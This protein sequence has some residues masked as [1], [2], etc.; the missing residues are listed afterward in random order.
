[1]TARSQ[2]ETIRDYLAP[3]GGQATIAVE[4]KAEVPTLE[5]GLE[6]PRTRT[7]FPPLELE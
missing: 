3:V 6:F 2:L 7:V 1:M 4:E 5:Q